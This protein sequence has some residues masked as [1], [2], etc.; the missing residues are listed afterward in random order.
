MQ[1]IKAKVVI[2]MYATWWHEQNAR[3]VQRG[4]CITLGMLH[5][6]SRDGSGDEDEEDRLLYFGDTA[7]NIDCF[8]SFSAS[9][10]PYI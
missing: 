3:K 9:L 5:G 7:Q 4:L 10:P 6:D 1:F 2:C 8:F